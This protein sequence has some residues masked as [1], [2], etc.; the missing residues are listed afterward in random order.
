[1]GVG[2]ILSARDYMTETMTKNILLTRLQGKKNPTYQG[3]GP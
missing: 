1:M 2:K 3:W